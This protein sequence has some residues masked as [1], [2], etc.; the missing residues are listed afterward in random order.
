MRSPRLQ[1]RASSRLQPYAR[2]LQPHVPRLQPDAPR[3]QPDAPRYDAVAGE[4][5]AGT[6]AAVPAAVYEAFG[7]S[8]PRAAAVGG[9]GGE[10]GEGGE[11]GEGWPTVL[12]G[13]A[14]PLNHHM[15]NQ[16]MPD[17]HMPNQHVGRGARAPPPVCFG[18][19]FPDTDAAFGGAGPF[20]THSD[21]LHA[22]QP[23][24]THGSSGGSRD[25]NR[26]GSRGG[27]RGGGAHRLLLLNPPFGPREMLG[28]ARALEA[29]LHA[30]VV[31]SSEVVSGSE[32]VSSAA[33][34][35]AEPGSTRRTPRLAQQGCTSTSA[36]VVVPSLAARGGG[37]PPHLAALLASPHLAGSVRLKAGEHSFLHGIAHRIS[38]RS[39]HRPHRHESVALLLSSHPAAREAAAAVLE[40]VRVAFRPEDAPS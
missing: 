13:F 36:L 28:L 32:V 11:G 20:D 38:R 14:S 37:T 31:S 18:S 9:E 29:V 22:P 21:A 40:A 8:W 39:P 4:A 10:S 3:L 26:D 6:Q 2:R 30:E 19:A 34:P 33:S 16:H 17:Q 5:G 23:R 27:S 1:P 12:E 24:S 35:H 25:G 7:R 15:P